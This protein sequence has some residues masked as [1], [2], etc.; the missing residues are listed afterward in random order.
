MIV[1]DQAQLAEW[2]AALELAYQRTP[3]AARQ[4]QV[5]HAL[6]LIDT[7]VLDP[8]GIWVARHKGA[9]VGVQVCM[10]LEGSSFLFWLPETRGG[11]VDQD[12]LVKAAIAWCRAQGGKLAQAILPTAD[13][14]RVV[15][16]LRQ[17]FRR[18]TQLLYLDH[19]L[20]TLPA[21]PVSHLVFEPF[22]ADNE[23]TFRQTLSRSYEGT[24]DCP[25]L[26]GV[27]T[28]DE[29]LAGYRS[30]S[31]GRPAGW[32]LL[33]SGGE[34]AGVLILTEMTEDG[35]W[36]LSYIG[37]VPEQRRRGIARVAV[38]HALQTAHA[39]GATQMLLAVDV[40][41][42]PARRLYAALGF[43]QTEMRDVYLYLLAA[44]ESG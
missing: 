37:V 21:A 34:P 12:E 38:C 19:S 35:A 31:A 13:A 23:G 20:N 33:R 42:D 8:T 17:G 41:N 6:H 28:I 29:I 39:A 7:G 2:P 36:D 4:L 32:W 22:T 40:R 16:L 24:L 30:T 25:E 44:R 3:H 5:V 1:F 18:V 14:D 43:T 9:I 26:N 11:S 27:R 10:P 15:P